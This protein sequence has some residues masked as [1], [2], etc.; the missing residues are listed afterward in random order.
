MWFSN[1]IKMWHKISQKEIYFQHSECVVS[2]QHGCL[3]VESKLKDVELILRKIY[4]AGVV[5]VVSKPLVFS[6][7]RQLESNPP[8]FSTLA[9]TDPHGRQGLTSA[10]Q[11]NSQAH[12]TGT[13]Y[14][15]FCKMKLLHSHIY[16]LI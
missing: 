3:Y 12:I 1:H 14:F 4:L 2:K 9:A 7:T 5:L 10:K 11:I 15:S 16:T 8:E 13:T 6:L